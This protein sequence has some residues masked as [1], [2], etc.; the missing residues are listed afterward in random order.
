MDEKQPIPE[1]LSITLRRPVKIGDVEY[2]VM[3]L[4]E[5][6]AGEMEQVDGES[7][8]AKK[9]AMIAL[10]S[11]I[12]AKLLEEVGVRD[13]D[14]A[15]A[16]LAR[17]SEIEQIAP[18]VVDFPE[19]LGEVTMPLRRPV[20]LGNDT[21]HELHLR[22]PTAGEMIQLDKLAGWKADVQAISL[23]SGIPRAAVIKIGERD[24]RRASEYLGRFFPAGR[25]TGADD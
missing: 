20:E 18:I 17:F 9:V 7:G 2:A 1:T 22:E 12:P 4:R 24:A 21:W 6:T 19:I 15:T 11:G 3:T 25:S 16:Y 8:W 10:V 13:I 14:L 23:I 5:P